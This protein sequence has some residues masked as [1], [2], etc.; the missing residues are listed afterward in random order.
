MHAST[1]AS[2]DERTFRD[3]VAVLHELLDLLAEE[4]RILAAPTG[5]ISQ[6]M[7]RR[8]EDLSARYARLTSMIRPR[9]S[10]LHAA[11]VLDPV[12][13]EAD[14]RALVRR[15]KE[16]QALLNARKAATALRVEAVM[17]ALAAREREGA[18]Y[19]GSGETLARG[20]CSVAGL[21]LSA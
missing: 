15:V 18:G 19:S 12:A 10:A 9:T 20:G 2:L 7:V 6:E 13:V 4:N 3:F 21:H 5:E 14:I 8:K 11:G 17:T 16:N 1:L